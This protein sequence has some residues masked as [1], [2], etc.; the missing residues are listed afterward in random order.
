[1]MTDLAA[2]LAGRARSGQW[3][4]AQHQDHFRGMHLDFV[5]HVLHHLAG[6][7]I[8]LTMGV[9]LKVALLITTAVF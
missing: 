5:Q 7:S 9:D 2:G 3:F 1:M 6:T 4:G 8:R